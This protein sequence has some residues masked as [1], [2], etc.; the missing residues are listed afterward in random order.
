MKIEELIELYAHSPQAAELASALSNTNIQRLSIDGISASAAPVLFAAATHRTPSTMM[1]MKRD[2][3]IT[4][5]LN[6]K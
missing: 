4:T 2:T 1:P 3:S 6:S 5:L